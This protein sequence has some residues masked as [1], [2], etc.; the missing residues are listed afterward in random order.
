MVAGTVALMLSAAPNLTNA[1]V[2]S[3]LQAHGASVPHR[4]RHRAAA[5]GL[6]GADVQQ[7][8]AGRVHLHDQHLRR[9]HARRRRG[10]DGRRTRCPPA[11][12]RRHGAQRSSPTSASVA[13]G[14][15]VTLDGSGSTRRLQRRDA[16]L[17]VVDRRRR[18]PPSRWARPRA[19]ASSLTGVAAGTGTVKLTVTDPTSGVTTAR[20]ST[21]TVTAATSSGGGTGGGGGGG[22]GARQPGLAGGTGA[23]RP[24]AGPRARRRAHARRAEPRASAP[25]GLP[26]PPR[27]PPDWPAA[28][29]DGTAS[30]RRAPRRPPSCAPRGAEA[31]RSGSTWTASGETWWSSRC[32]SRSGCRACGSESQPEV[33]ADVDQHE[34]QDQARA[35]SAQ[36]PRDGVAPAMSGRRASRGPREPHAHFAADDAARLAA[37]G[38]LERAVGI[39]AVGDAFGHR[40]VGGAHRLAAQ[41]VAPR[42]G[43]A[44]A[45]R[46][47]RARRRAARAPAARRCGPGCPAAWPRATARRARRR[48]SRPRPPAAAATL[49]PMPIT[50]A[51]CSPTAPTRSGCRPACGP[52]AAP[53]RR[54]IRRQRR[55][56]I[57]SLGHFRPRRVPCGSSASTTARP[58]ASDSPD[59]SARCSGSASENVS[60]APGVECQRRP[61]AAAAGRLVDGH[62]QLR[63]QVVRRGRR[64]GRPATAARATALRRRSVSSLLVESR[65][66]HDLDR[67]PRQQR[68]EGLPQCLRA[69]VRARGARRLA[70]GGLWIGHEC[71]KWGESCGGRGA[72]SASWATASCRGSR[73][74]RSGTRS[75]S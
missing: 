46:S 3:I 29:V 33:Q 67:Q 11:P 75:A 39:D 48:R 62:E 57:R 58:T 21:V 38:D 18:P 71:W 10:R 72:G 14:G 40:A 32:G 55:S 73:A 28:T 63:E 42:I 36:R 25:G 15:T 7:R 1:Q 13:A 70:R 69:P 17:P 2:V 45:A 44:A 56:R 43:A 16:D 24:A 51:R 12:P 74:C 5:A 20:P 53:C 23:G 22:G 6:H 52:R 26:T 37:A 34:Q 59:Q 30:S 31:G 9:R 50:A 61:E 27:W 64:G 66:L 60:D 65:R 19:R 68:H 4:Q 49:M 41:H 54:P 35:A 8:R 47:R